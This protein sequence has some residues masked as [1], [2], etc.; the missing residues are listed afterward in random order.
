[1]PVDCES[2]VLSS[3]PPG[4]EL[5]YVLNDHY[6]SRVADLHNSRS[7][8]GRSA[9][10]HE[11]SAS[12][13]NAD[14]EAEE[15][16]QTK[17]TTPSSIISPHT[18]QRLS[19]WAEFYQCNPE[20][21]ECECSSVERGSG[22]GKR[23]ISFADELGRQLEAIQI[24]DEMLYEPPKLSISAYSEKENVIATKLELT[25]PQPASDYMAFWNT[26]ESKC[27]S[28]ENVIVKNHSLVGTVRV[29]NISFEKKVLVRYTFNNWTSFSEQ[30]AHYIPTGVSD[31]H[32]STFTFTVEC[33]SDFTCGSQLLFAVQYVA[34]GGQ[35]FWDN[36]NG[37]NYE[38][39][40]ITSSSIVL[41]GSMSQSSVFCGNSEGLRT[42]F[43]G[44]D[45]S[46]IDLN[47]PY[48]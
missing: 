6:G 18:Q 20:T 4:F 32:F 26:V 43:S 34:C 11:L 31:D 24:V 3:S 46:D 39:I 15:A 5:N 33:P 19:S 47:S 9:T 45:W 16:E 10:W 38:V 25:F 2:F 8:F 42:E 44:W 41:Q 14:E 28:L 12:L 22:M 7:R 13:T 17:A 27:V 23:K 29:K 35:E 37:N 30:Q 21:F 40:C 36:N 1:M 48:W